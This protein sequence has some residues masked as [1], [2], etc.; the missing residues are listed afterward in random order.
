M[1][2]QEELP[3]SATV[4]DENRRQ[5]RNSLGKCGVLSDG[6]CLPGGLQRGAGVAAG[7]AFVPSSATESFTSFRGG[8]GTEASSRHR[9]FRRFPGAVVH[10][11][12][13][14]KSHCPPVAIV[15]C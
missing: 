15:A 8:D 4:W 6:P 2:R 1:C 3:P 7:R 10:P 11:E 13:Y 9:P 14:F 5:S 12:I